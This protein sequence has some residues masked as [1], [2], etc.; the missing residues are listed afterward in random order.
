MTGRRTPPPSAREL[1]QRTLPS[2]RGLSRKQSAVYLGLSAKTFSQSVKNGHLPPPRL[3]PTAGGAVERWD[4]KELDDA[5]DRLP[6]RGDAGHPP[7]PVRRLF[8]L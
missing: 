3:I 1:R 7:A 5:F 8:D 4:L 2:N 6:H